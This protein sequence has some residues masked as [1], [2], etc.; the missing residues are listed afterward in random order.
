MWREDIAEQLAAARRGAARRGSAG[1]PP[2]RPRRPPGVAR[3]SRGCS[4]SRRPPVRA[5]G[6]REGAAAR[7]LRSPRSRRSSSAFGRAAAR[8][9][10]AG[11]D[12]VELHAGHGYLVHQF[13]SA[14]SNLRDGRVR[15]RD[16]W[17]SAPAS[18]STV[19]SRDPPGG[20]GA[21]ARRAAERRRT[22][23]RAAS[24]PGD[25][26]EAAA[27]LRRS[28]SPRGSS[29]RPASTDRCPTRS[30]CSTT[31]GVAR[32]AR[33]VPEAWADG[34]GALGRRHRAAGRRRGGA[35]T[36]RLRRR[37]SSGGR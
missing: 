18:G 3:A 25:A 4:P 17:R 36:R 14:A 32:R 33:V 13:L 15:R 26:L 10:E 2:A 6:P 9:A 37:S 1:V 21:R 12:A 34:A 11:F 28:R 20:A 23:C 8:A 22:S 16:D 30:R 35:P 27:A 7:A 29:S 31:R 24:R 19:V 5:A